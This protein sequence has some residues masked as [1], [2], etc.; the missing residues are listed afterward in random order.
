MIR[1]PL[2]PSR[3]ED[4]T[5]RAFLYAPDPQTVPHRQRCMGVGATV[6]NLW[7]SMHLLPALRQTL[8]ADIQHAQHSTR[9]QVQWV[10]TIP[11]GLLRSC[12]ACM[13][14]HVSQQSKGLLA[15][16]QVDTFQHSRSSV[17]RAANFI[18]HP[19]KVCRYA[20]HVR[21]DTLK[22]LEFYS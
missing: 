17:M 21:A 2:G 8:C 7:H 16:S 4:W 20:S 19:G 14:E 18:V 13:S 9:T 22:E 10:Q 3:C 1:S 6:A 11:T 12:H 5:Q 15:S